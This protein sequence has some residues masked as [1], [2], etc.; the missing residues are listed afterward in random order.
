[1]ARWRKKRNE[2]DV[3]SADR[4]TADMQRFAEIFVSGGREEGQDV[5]FDVATIYRLDEL[6]D[7][8]LETG[9]AADV[10]QS[11]TLCMGAFLGEMII[12]TGGG[13]WSIR[14]GMPGVTT[15]GRL[16]CFPINKVGKRLTEGP[17]HN[18][19]QFFDTAVTD[20]HPQTSRVEP[21]SGS[22]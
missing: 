13:T 14:E 18:L 15:A 7:R 12:R 22:S 10:V 16:M 2:A 17:H 11:M 20:E 4:V 21:G 5:S 19:A 8:F 1:M 6:A 3:V 9:P